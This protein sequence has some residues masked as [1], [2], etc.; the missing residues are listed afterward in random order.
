MNWQTPGRDG[1]VPG[2]FPN[3]LEADSIHLTL[4]RGTLG[5]RVGPGSAALAGT[6][7]GEW[8]DSGLGRGRHEI[9]VLFF[10]GEMKFW[11]LQYVIPSI[12]HYYR[13][14]YR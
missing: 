4:R 14:Y 1:L 8:N 9:A 12:D 6:G 5:H 11:I 13:F 10:S 7:H 2:I 3:T